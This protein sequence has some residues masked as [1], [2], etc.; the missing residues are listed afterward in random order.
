MATTRKRKHGTAAPRM[1]RLRSAIALRSPMRL[2]PETPQM[3]VT[4]AGSESSGAVP[5]A[6]TFR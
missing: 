1:I 6:V 4:P 3:M 5:A 2:H